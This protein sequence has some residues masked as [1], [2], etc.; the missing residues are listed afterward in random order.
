MG[1]AV[2]KKG[3]WGSLVYK[4]GGER[5]AGTPLRHGDPKKRNGLNMM[6]VRY[7]VTRAL[8]VVSSIQKHLPNIFYSNTE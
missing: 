8:F 5:T 7:V 3:G 2:R 4:R 1:G 6:E